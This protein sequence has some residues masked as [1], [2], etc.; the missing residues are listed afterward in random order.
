MSSYHNTRIE[1]T[2]RVVEYATTTWPLAVRW[3]HTQASKDMVLIVWWMGTLDDRQLITELHRRAAPKCVSQCRKIKATPTRCTSSL[4][5]NTLSNP[6]TI[7]SYFST[8]AAL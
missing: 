2:S 8:S 4:Q 6:S 7:Q 5:G 3:Q 1:D